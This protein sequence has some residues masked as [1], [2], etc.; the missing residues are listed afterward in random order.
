M[1]KYYPQV[2]GRGLMNQTAFELRMNYLNSL[3]ENFNDDIK[4][5]TIHLSEVQ[6]NIESFI[7]TVEIPL[8]LIGPILF[9]DKNA[10]PEWVHTAL[11]TTEGA[12]VASMNRGA[13]AISQCGGFRAHT[14]HQKMLRTPMFTFSTMT[15]ALIF[16]EWIESNF[17]KI[18]SITKRHSNHAELLEISSVVVGKIIHLKFIYTTSDASGQNM[19]TACTWNACLWIEENFENQTNIEILHFVIEG[20]GASD[21]KVSYSS[22]Q[23]GRGTRVI[24]ECF[25]T[26]E[27]IEK[28]L[29]TNTDDMFRS[30][31]HS[32]AISRLDGMIGNNINVANAI[33]GIFGS[34]GQD[35]ASIHESS[36]AVL[37]MEQNKDGLYVSL[38]LPNLVIGSV[39]GGTHLPV[40]SGILK[41]M[42]CKGAGKTERFAKLIAGF[43]L[44]LEISTLAAIVSGQFARAH[45]KLGRNKPVKWLLKSEVNEKFFKSNMP[46]FPEEIESVDF[47]ETGQLDNGILTQLTGK[48]SKKLLGFIQANV[49]TPGGKNYPVL[50]KSKA[51]GDELLDGLHFMASNVSVELADLM[52][53]Y[54]DA[55]EYKN[56]HLKEIEIYEALKSKNF[57]FIP[58]FYGSVS[59]QKREIYLF[60]FERLMPEKMFLFNSE[61]SPD[62]WTTDIIKKAI[63]AIHIVHSAFATVEEQRKLVSIDRFDII[64]PTELYRFFTDLNR[65]DYDYLDL[66]NRF[67]QMN[68]FV[69]SWNQYGFHRKGKLTLIHNDFNPRNVGIR[70]NGQ[71][72]IYDWELATYGLPQ[73]DI[74]EFLA[75]TLTDDSISNHLIDLLKYHYELVKD[76]NPDEY[77]WEDYISDFILAG[78]AFLVSRVNFYL[79]GSTLVNYSFIER[80]FRISFAI[81]DSIE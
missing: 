37:Q 59:N 18:K 72:C 12:L 56:S 34:T 10:V 78:Q 42:G 76:F 65:K 31:N 67:E 8:G 32:S 26:N 22:M 20:N 2:P 68:D 14:I 55:L 66:D 53:K 51:L 7:G 11:A 81:L 62:R 58:E 6:N 60:I 15:E 13:K 48:V 79:A 5:E 46:Y 3:V 63:D 40:A 16:D 24:S 57:P 80:V 33:A 45:Q 69:I 75:F 41:L 25:L 28:T 44:S 74:F 73:R 23:N 54:K 49:K 9:N 70:S 61:D 36:T 52:L 29:R 1:K 50:L 39:G 77:S 64:K 71:P 38:T 17:K 43:A 47:N 21:K 27:I 19:T 4:S 30:F 35:L